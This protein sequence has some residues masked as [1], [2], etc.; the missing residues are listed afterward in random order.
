M[1]EDTL[2]QLAR[3]SGATE[4]GGMWL[5]TRED[6]ARFRDAVLE[7]AAEICDRQAAIEINVRAVGGA[8]RC[9]EA[10]RELKGTQ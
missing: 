6:L 1:T 9:A 2:T 8:Q 5:A 4:S 10:T 7:E 3:S